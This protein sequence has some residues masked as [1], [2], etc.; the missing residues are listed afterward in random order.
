MPWTRRMPPTTVRPSAGKAGQTSAVLAWA[1]TRRASTSGPTAP[2]MV[3]SIFLKTRPSR[4]RSVIRLAAS[5]TPSAASAGGRG[6]LHEEAHAAAAREEG[7]R[8]AGTREVV[9]EDGERHRWSEPY[10]RRHPHDPSSGPRY[11]A[12]MSGRAVAA[13]LVPAGCGKTPQAAQKGPDARRR[14]MRRARR[15]RCTLSEERPSQRSRWAFF[16][17]R[18]AAG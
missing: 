12:V 7:A 14:G 3:E 9:G 16:S 1:A 10:H 8:V 17:G 13:I 5:R 18:L 6:G 4:R 11:T 15:T 2:R